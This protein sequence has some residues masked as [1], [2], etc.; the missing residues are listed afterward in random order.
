M[1]QME[2][3]GLPLHKE[4]FTYA[5]PQWT[6]DGLG[7][8]Q[9]FGTLY[10]S[11]PVMRGLYDMLKKV[12]PTDATV[13]I[14]GESGSGK[15]LVATTIHQISARAS[16][17]FVA[18]NCSAIPA[19]LIEAELFGHE[20]GSF[21]GAARQ[22]KGHFERACGGT[23]FLDEITEMPFDLQAT[24][25]RA[26]ESRKFRRVGGDSEIESH[27]RIIAATNY[28]ITA[29]IAAKKIREDLLYRL[30]VFP[31][32]VP[33]LR[34]R[35]N[36][37]LELAE[38]FLSELNNETGFRKYLLDSAKE[39]L[40]A[41]PWPGNVR[42]LKNTIQRAYILADSALDF[43]EL[44]SHSHPHEFRDRDKWDKCV[45]V[46]I[47]MSLDEA[48][49]QIIYA[50]LN[51]YGGNKRDTAKVLGISLKTLYNRLAEYQNS[52][53]SSAFGSDA[54]AVNRSATGVSVPAHS[55]NPAGN[56][57]ERRNG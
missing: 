41:H 37:V 31:I 44:L 4:H 34:E 46:S 27:A 8:T 16:Q 48:E 19:N 9:Q 42:E 39:A 5:Q 12:A 30:S 40:K 24:L 23:L 3:I 15:E 35:G 10:G 43:T 49:R 51:E 52:T 57:I 50:T 1:D 22:H 29:A 53:E 13:F 32:A 55:Q 21:T 18:V 11:S 36:D 45:P 25:L 7:I 14:V 38:L 6:N 28:P 26:L 2:S 54:V 33:A 17:P 56:L 20:K 47:G